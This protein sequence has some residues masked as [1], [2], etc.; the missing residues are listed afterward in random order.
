[1]RNMPLASRKAKIHYNKAIDSAKEICAKGVQGQAYLGLGNL[2]IG[3]GKKDQASE[4][5]AS[6]IQMFE[7]C[8]AETFLKRA[9]EIRLSMS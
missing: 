2:Y 4:C 7:L 1:M 6:A 8:G 5:I 3:E 9:N